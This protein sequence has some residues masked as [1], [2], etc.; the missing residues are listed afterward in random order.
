[1]IEMGWSIYPNLE[2]WI[3]RHCESAADF[4]RRID[5]TYSSFKDFMRG[6]NGTTK[7]TI[8]KILSVTGLTYEVCFKERKVDKNAGR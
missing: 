8:D 2:H 3:W 6:K 1:M 5:Y 7:Y 4:A